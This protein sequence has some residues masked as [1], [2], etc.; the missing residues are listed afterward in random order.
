MSDKALL[1]KE[2]ILNLFN[3]QSKITEKNCCSVNRF[4]ADCF[5]QYSKTDGQHKMKRLKT[6]KERSH[7]RGGGQEASKTKS[8]HPHC[9]W[10]SRKDMACFHN[11]CY[12]RCPCSSK[13]NAPFPNAIPA[14]QEPS[15]I[16]DNRLIGHHGLFNHEVKS[17]DIERLLSDQRKVEKSGQQLHKENHAV[18]DPSSTLLIASPLSHNDLLGA[19]TNRVVPFEK[20]ADPA[21][22]THDECWEKKLSHGSDITSGQRP[23]QEPYLSSGSHKSIFS[24]KRSSHKEV[25]SKKPNSVV[26]DKDRKSLLSPPVEN[27]KILNQI[28]TFEHTPKKQ[29]PPAQQ[30]Q[31][32][33]LHSSPPQISTSPT[34]DSFDI[35]HRQDPNHVFNSVS[36][37]AARLCDSL[38]FPF[39]TRRNLATE[40]REV[41]LKALQERHGPQLHENLLKVQQCLNFGTDL[42]AKTVQD[43]EP[44]VIVENEL[45]LTAVHAS[46]A[47]QHCFDTQISTSFKMPGSTHVQPQQSLE[48]AAEW[49]TG[50]EDTS[51]SLLDNIFRQSCSP[52]LRIDFEPVSDHLFCS[53]ATPRWGE[54]QKW[55]DSFNRQKTKDTVVFDSFGSSFMNHNRP[56]KQRSC[57]PQNSSSNL[58]PFF[59]HQEQIPDRHLAELVHFPPEQDPFDTDRYRFVSSF[60][61]KVLQSN[62]S[63]HFHPFSEF[64]HSSTCPPL[65]SHHTD[66]MHYPPS[67]MLETKLSSPF[68]SFPSPENWSFPPMKL[69]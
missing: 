16:T 8:H 28:S 13:R 52:H 24:S 2:K 44:T 35:Q 46:T 21:T 62:Q 31:A 50:P 45:L 27:M 38:H 55:D 14:T 49:P 36:V 40:S 6:R 11:C 20:K 64:G 63:R 30:N 19:N 48:R 25:K 66:M 39:L 1:N 43:Q 12:S 37:M 22:N 17:T 42:V 32:H 3:K 5:N 61:T 4:T 67:H 26:C 47:S 51:A 68:S 69:Y 41:L 9:C 65:M 7:M 54:S 57:E 15:I 18:S 33:G 23:Q 56:V 10:Q 59:S 53:S 29:E 34:A 58:Q 60:S